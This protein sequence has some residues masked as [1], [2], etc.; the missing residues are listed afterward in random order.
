MESDQERVQLVPM[1]HRP[2][3]AWNTYGLLYGP[4][5]VNVSLNYAG[6]KC[7]RL[8]LTVL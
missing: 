8:A 3:Q 6:I 5:V 1:D 4:T 7:N 2:H